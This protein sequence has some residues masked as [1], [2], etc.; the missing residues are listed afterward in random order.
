MKYDIRT[1]F[2]ANYRQIEQIH[3]FSIESNTLLLEH[4]K[5]ENN[6]PSPLHLRLLHQ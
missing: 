5:M 1:V 3:N 2:I 4:D 6:I